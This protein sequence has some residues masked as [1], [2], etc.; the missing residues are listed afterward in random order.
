MTPLF[1]EE[2]TASLNAFLQPGTLCV[3]DFDG[4]LAPI[5]ALPEHARLPETVRARLLLLQQLA[6]VAI[7][8][9]RALADIRARLDF[10]ADFVIGNHGLEGLP[11]SASRRG[12]F[13]ALCDGWRDVLRNAFSDA[14]R[15]DAA[16]ALEDKQISLSVHYRQAADRS[17]TEAALQALFA[18]LTP[19][20]RMISGKCVFNLLPQAAGDKGTA[21]EQLMVLSGASRAIYVGDDMTDEDVFSLRRPD[22]LSIRVAQAPDSAAQFYLRRYNDIA[23]LLDHVIDRLQLA[24]TPAG[25][26]PAVR[27]QQHEKE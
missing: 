20:P 4:T 1:S 2:G 16:I 12:Y 19:A 23:R 5:V 8:T 18:I 26:L 24:A 3:F 15:F 22:L 7:L 11:D 21:F 14:S 6:P 17:A 13:E 25:A 10:N 9:G 27:T